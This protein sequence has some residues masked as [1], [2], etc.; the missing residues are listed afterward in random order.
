MKR[1]QEQCTEVRLDDGGEELEKGKQEGRRLR[2]GSVREKRLKAVGRKKEEENKEE[3][4]ERWLRGERRAE[5]GW[6]ER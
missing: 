5:G 3:F 2:E 4:R 1:L 6:S